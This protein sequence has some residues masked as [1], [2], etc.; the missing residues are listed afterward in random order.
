[1]EWLY[2]TYVGAMG[3]SVSEYWCSSYPEVMAAIRGWQRHQVE[4]LEV[5]TA[6]QE[7]SFKAH[8]HMTAWLVSAWSKGTVTGAEILPLDSDQEE[9]E[10]GKLDSTALERLRASEK[11]KI[12]EKNRLR[13]ERGEE[14]IRI[15]GVK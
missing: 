11:A 5:Q 15:R 7:Q 8:R 6:L 13:V 2:S 12:A 1:M 4:L 9:K 14:P 3:H 10:K